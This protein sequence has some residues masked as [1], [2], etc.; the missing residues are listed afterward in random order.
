MSVKSIRFVLFGEERDG[1]LAV[2][3]LTVLLVASLFPFLLPLRRSSLAVL[4]TRYLPSE[5]QAGQIRNVLRMFN[6]SCS[7]AE[8]GE[9]SDVVLVSATDWLTFGAEGMVV[10]E[11]T[12]RQPVNIAV[13]RVPPQRAGG[14][15]GNPLH[16]RCAA[17]VANLGEGGKVGRVSSRVWTE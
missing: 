3:L 5:L 15:A 2:S 10:G 17:K 9:V 7:G 6:C 13:D 4:D 12:R 1:I 16:L 14:E 8:K 11:V